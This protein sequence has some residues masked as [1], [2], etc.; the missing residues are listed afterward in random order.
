M[1]A[2]RA[3]RLRVVQHMLGR[4]AL[5]FVVVPIL[6]LAL[7]VQIGQVVGFW[8]TMALVVTTGVLGAALA[9]AQGLRALN[10]FRSE[11]AAGRMPGDAALDGLAVLI[12]G[13]FLLTPGLLT[14]VTGFLLLLPPTRRWIQRRVRH[15]LESS[16]ASGQLRV[17]VLDPGGIHP[18]G[19]QAEEES[20]DRELDPRHEIDGG[21]RD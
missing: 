9:R 2:D 1:C 7:L 13:A 6:E 8:P 20:G 19:V 15:W 10:R 5:L 12:G 11:L 3:T 18:F 16:V 14:D 21:Y 17:T 4:L